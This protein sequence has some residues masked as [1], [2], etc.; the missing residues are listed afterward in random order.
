[1][2]TLGAQPLFSPHPESGEGRGAAG[3]TLMST[4]SAATI[5][6]SSSAHHARC[7]LLLVAEL[8]LWDKVNGV[9]VIFDQPLEKKD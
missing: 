6:A 4:T 8:F 5:C 1:V 2:H 9:F 3:G 7:M